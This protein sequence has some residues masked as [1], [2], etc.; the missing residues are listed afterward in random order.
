MSSLV[1]LTGATGFVGSHVAES[2]MRAGYRV[3]C[4]VRATSDTRWIEGRE[5][6]TVTIDLSSRSM[7]EAAIDGVEHVVH[8][9]VLTRA[10][11]DADYFF[12]NAEITEII[13]SPAPRA[14][15]RRFVLVSS[16]A[17]RG[18]DGGRGPACP[19]GAS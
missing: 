6:E 11:Y 3:R 18:P 2:L 4:A 12:V 15:V 14:S 5:V 9:D 10:R 1:F 19:Y 7:L 13:A 17:A 16:L 8:A